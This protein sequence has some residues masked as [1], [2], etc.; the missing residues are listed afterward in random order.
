MERNEISGSRQLEFVNLFPYIREAG[1]E[2]EEKAAEA[3]REYLKSFGV[4]SRLEPFEFETIRV[5]KE[6]FE[7]TE[8]YQKEYPAKAYGGFFT[9]TPEE[10]IEA[11]FLYVENGS[12]ISLSHAK[13]KIV[14]I[15]EVMETSMWYKRVCDA[16]AVGFASIG[17][18]PID[19]GL[20][21]IPQRRSVR[22]G[23]KNIQG[24]R[25]HYLDAQE[26]I[27]KGA[28][29]A[30]ITICREKYICKSANVIARI[31]GT[32]KA[33]E[34]LTLT[35]HYDSVPEGPGAYDNMSGAA[36]I[37]ELC[38]YF[39]AHRP[40]RTMEFI[41]FGAEEK[42]LR[43]SKAY[44]EAHADELSNHQFNMNVDLAGQAVGGTVIGLTADA[45]ACDV[46]K[47]F[48]AEIDLGME[49]IHGIWAS[50]S[51]TFAW[52]GIPAMTLNRD[53]FGMHTHY[54]TADR[55][56]AWSLGRSATL[57]GYIAEQLGNLDEIP[58]DRHVPE[59]FV[60]KLEPMYIRK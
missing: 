54:D 12:L 14:M 1:T 15:N 24:V 60:K 58:F 18:S 41:W 57:L 6:S 49:L 26:M 50:D 29:K 36:I 43:G 21:R 27:E 37:M 16:D 4:D 2:G 35:A 34:V 9:S 13:D 38:R 56:S 33:D 46:I 25:V 8:P 17:G 19:Q 47:R 30:R 3:I 42:G 31:E 11:D 53:G 20:D 55:I 59:E 28:S 7:V 51:N 52:K 22:G 44:I 45:N 32:D 39:S 5:T 10:G 40:R 23:E 48:A